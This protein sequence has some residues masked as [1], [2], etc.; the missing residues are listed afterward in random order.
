[1][2]RS[3]LDRAIQRCDSNAF[4]LPYYHVDLELETLLY[5]MLNFLNRAQAKALGQDAAPAMF[6]QEILK[7]V[8][9]FQRDND[10]WTAD[11]QSAFMRNILLGLKVQPLIFYAIGSM[12]NKSSCF[13][14]DGLQRVTS[15]IRFFKDPDM[16]ISFSDQD[17]EFSLPAGVILNDDKFKRR[18]WSLSVPLR[19]YHFKTESDAVR[20]YI[21]MNEGVTHSPA[22]IQKARNYLA[23]LESTA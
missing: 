6:E 5:G 22:D 2:K 21:E 17:G 8:P 19:I 13:L 3:N 15:T 16:P 7:R 18:I 9:E 4:N 23:R 12:D 1:M 11:M 14:L 20:H 10:K